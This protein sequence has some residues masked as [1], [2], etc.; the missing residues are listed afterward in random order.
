MVIINFKIMI[1][2]NLLRIDKNDFYYRE[3]DL[4]A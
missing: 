3:G 4:S 1:E 2:F